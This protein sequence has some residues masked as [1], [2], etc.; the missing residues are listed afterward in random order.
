MPH[1]P[2]RL[3]IG[4]PRPSHEALSPPVCAAR[5]HLPPLRHLCSRGG[6]GVLFK[7]KSFCAPSLLFPCHV[8]LTIQPEP[9]PPPR[10]LGAPSAASLLTREPPLTGEGGDRSPGISAEMP[11]VVSRSCSRVPWIAWSCGATHGLSPVLA[12]VRPE[13]DLGLAGAWESGCILGG[14]GDVAMPTHLGVEGRRDSGD[15]MR[16]GELLHPLA[17][18]ESLL[19]HSNQRQPSLGIR[20]PSRR[21]GPLEEASVGEQVG[22]SEAG[23]RGQTLG[24]ALP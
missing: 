7:A 12:P 17:P 13:K 14:R 8:S 18:R 6:S 21:P 24:G 19:F 2:W 22:S 16:K 3:L 23:P 11:F 5:S 4:D 9:H 15:G 10:P 1:V 20:A